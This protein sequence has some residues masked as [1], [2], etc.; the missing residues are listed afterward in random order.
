MMKLAES[1]SM[2]ILSH[3]G[4]TSLLSPTRPRPNTYHTRQFSSLLLQY[5]RYKEIPHPRDMLVQNRYSMNTRIPNLGLE[6]TFWKTGVHFV[7]WPAEGNQII[8]NELII[9]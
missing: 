9:Q 2:K 3:S 1:G 8:F 5:N 4:E 7:S 6:S